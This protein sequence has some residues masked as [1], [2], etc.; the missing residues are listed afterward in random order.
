MRRS[1]PSILGEPAVWLLVGVLV[2]MLV[3]VQA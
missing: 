1:R 2:V 3:G